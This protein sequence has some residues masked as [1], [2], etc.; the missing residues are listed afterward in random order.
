MMDWHF[1]FNNPSDGSKNTILIG[2]RPCPSLPIKLANLI[3]NDN[4]P[5]WQVYTES[6]PFLY[7]GYMAPYIHRGFI[8]VWSQ[9]R[10]WLVWGTENGLSCPVRLIQAGSEGIRRENEAAK[11]DG[12]L[13][14]TS[15]VECKG[16]N[17]LF[18]STITADLNGDFI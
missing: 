16:F 18:D 17:A 10:K 12:W 3:Q 6:C 1:V 5:C 9:Q 2:H 15:L 7:F 13:L 4:T 8:E 11:G 14:Q